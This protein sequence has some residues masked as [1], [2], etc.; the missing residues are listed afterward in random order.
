MNRPTPDAILRGWRAADGPETAGTA[1]WRRMPG[2][3]AVAAALLAATMAAGF[4]VDTEFAAEPLHESAGD[5]LMENPRGSTMKT[6]LKALRVAAV[7][8]SAVVS[9]AVT[10]SAQAQQPA[11]VQWRVENGG[12]GH[13]YLGC[14]ASKSITWSDA[15]GAATASGGHLATI[16]DEAEY[17]FVREQAGNS[18]LW[19]DRSGPWIGG[20]QDRGSSSF[21][22][23]AGGWRW[24]TDE[25]WFPHWG[26]GEPNNVGGLEDYLHFISTS[27][28]D[29]IPNRVLNDF[30]DASSIHP[31]APLPV[32]Y[33]VEWSADCNNDGI[34]DYGQIL[35]G[36]LADLDANGIPDTCEIVSCNDA[37]LTQNG[38][39]DG[40][41]L[42]AI[43]AF[44]GPTG[45]VLPQADINRD[46]QVNGADIGL[47][48]SFWGPC[49]G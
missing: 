36:E 33:I 29:P 1:R 20:F 15:R 42:G 46:G 49:G 39:V 44:W 38:T 40:A 14:A 3:R 34:V 18:A 32:G 13:W 9:F 26:P 47:L 4:A 22:E 19:I 41:D 25:T 21:S 45:Q 10:E 2:G 37:D 11:A 23:P 24:V 31:C 35:L 27:C 28:S 30:P 17:G 48:L 6:R 8:A 5:G 43:L 7:S 12:N 16:T